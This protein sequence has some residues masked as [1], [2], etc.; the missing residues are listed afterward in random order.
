MIY[1]W[2]VRKQALAAW[3]LLSDQRLDEIRIADNVHFVYLGDHPLAA[4]LHGADAVR[5]WLRNELFG[6]L[7]GLRFEV[8]DM[9]V[10]GN[11]RTTRMATRYAAKRDGQL[12][13]RGVQFVR[14]EWGRLVDECVLPD[15][16]ALTAALA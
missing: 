15:T 10:E 5:A 14:L 16:T 13:Y 4:D 6:R 3:Q 11:P 7:P 12:V 2:F 8:E 1:R 9:I